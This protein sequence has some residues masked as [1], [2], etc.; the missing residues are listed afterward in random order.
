MSTDIVSHWPVVVPVTVAAHEC[1]DDGYL[2][3]AGIEHLFAIARAAYFDLCTTV[4]RDTLG[5]RGVSIARGEAP[6]GAGDV[7]VAVG[8]TE[9]FPDSFTMTTRIRARDNYGIAATGMC[10]IAPAGEV[11]TAMR[12]EFIALAHAAR[13]MH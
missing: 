6:V 2:T 4:D 9:V 10:S 7:T 5:L 3:D 11:S 12:D 8:V 1:D 13:H